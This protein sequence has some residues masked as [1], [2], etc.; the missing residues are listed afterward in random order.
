MCLRG[1]RGYPARELFYTEPPIE[2]P[3]ESQKVLL[4]EFLC[5]RQ[6]AEAA[7]WIFPQLSATRFEIDG[8]SVDPTGG[9]GLESSRCKPELAQV[10]AQRREAIGHSA[11]RLATITDVQQS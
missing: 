11:S 9:P 3:V 6:V 2:H 8:T 10:I 5:G 4:F 1:G 7:G